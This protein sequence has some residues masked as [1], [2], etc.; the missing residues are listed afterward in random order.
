MTSDEAIELATQ[1]VAQKAGPDPHRMGERCEYRLMGARHAA[2]GTW[3]ILYQ[4]YLLGPPP[5]IIDGPLVVVVD[6]KSRKVCFFNELF[7]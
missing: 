3:S 6:P 4:T 7:S 5:S 2:D 1:Y